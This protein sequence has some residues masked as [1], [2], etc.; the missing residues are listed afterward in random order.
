MASIYPVSR[1]VNVFD[2]IHEHHCIPT[3]HS[4]VSC[5][6]VSWY[7]H[8][9]PLPLEGFPLLLE[10]LVFLLRVFQSRSRLS[11]CG[12]N[13]PLTSDSMCLQNCITA[14]MSSLS[15]GS[16]SCLSFSFTQLFGMPKRMMSRSL[17]L[18]SSCPVANGGS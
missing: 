8:H 14:W 15:Y 2:T 9:L 11:E 6:S 7:S 16:K 1:T 17:S 12:Q 10:N 13:L 3:E 18:D 4:L 5:V